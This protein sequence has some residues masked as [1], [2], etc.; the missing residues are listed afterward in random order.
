[1]RLL[2]L[3]SASGPGLPGIWMLTLGGWSEVDVVST[4]RTSPDTG[5]DTYSLSV[6]WLTAIVSGTYDS[7]VIEYQ[8]R[9]P[10]M[11]V[12]SPLLPRRMTYTTFL[13][14]LTTTGPAP[15]IGN[16]LLTC[17]VLPSTMES[18]PSPSL[19]AYTRLN[20]ELIAIQRG[21]RPTGMLASTDVPRVPS[22]TTTRLP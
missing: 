8:L 9:E 7:V 1:M 2:L 10:L 11:T 12:I 6:L 13:N 15:P 3:F 19:L 20:G 16:V 17:A 4:A 5:C 22:S 21:A 14:S 18:V